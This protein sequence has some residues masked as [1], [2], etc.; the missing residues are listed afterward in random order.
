VLLTKLAE[1]LGTEDGGTVLMRALGLLDL[2]LKAK[3]EGKT[4]GVYDPVR[5]ELS[6]V[7]F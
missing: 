7:A 1:A 4:L 3:R 5:D 6:E 2:A